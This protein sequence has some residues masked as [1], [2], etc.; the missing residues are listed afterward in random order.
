MNIKEQSTLGNIFSTQHIEKKKKFLLSPENRF[1]HF[2]Q[3]VSNRDSLHEMS[4]LFSRE[5][6]KNVISLS[7]ELAQRVIKVNAHK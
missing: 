3:I 7:S 5:N 1:R 4:T 2:M 6:K